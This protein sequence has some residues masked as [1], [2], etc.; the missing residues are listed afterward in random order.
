MTESLPFPRQLLE[1]GADLFITAPLQLAPMRGS[2]EA[3]EPAGAPLTHAVLLPGVLG[4][5]SLLCR[6][7]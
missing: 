5:G 2:Y 4:R 3:N 1:P 6:R 7:Q